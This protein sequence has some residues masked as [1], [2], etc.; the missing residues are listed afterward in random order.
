[1]RAVVAELP[2]FKVALFSG[3]RETPQA[4][5]AD[6]DRSVRGLPDVDPELPEDAR[7]LSMSSDWGTLRMVLVPSARAAA[8]AARWAIAL[9]PGGRQMNFAGA[10]HVEPDGYGGA[11]AAGPPPAA[12][13]EPIRIWCDMR[14][15]TSVSVSSV[16]VSW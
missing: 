10:C 6:H 12:G 5:A 4:P 13:P 8:K 16:S 14:S 9:S 15:M 2:G 3:R 1:M 7:L 11:S